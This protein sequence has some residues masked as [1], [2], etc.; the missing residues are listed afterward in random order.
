MD[1]SGR[2][3]VTPPPWWEQTGP[4][5]VSALLAAARSGDEAA[6]ADLV[7]R[8]EPFLSALIAGAGIDRAAGESI[9]EG[10][11]TRLSQELD[12]IDDEN[13]LITWVVRAVPRYTAGRYAEVDGTLNG[14]S[15]TERRL[16]RFIFRGESSYADI[17]SSLDM[18][19]GSVGPARQRLFRRLWRLSRSGL[20][21][22]E[23]DP[24]PDR[25]TT[26]D[27]LEAALRIHGVSH[28]TAS[29]EH[30]DGWI[31][32]LA[33]AFGLVPPPWPSPPPGDDLVVA[34]SRDVTDAA[35]E[36]FRD[37]TRVLSEH[38]VLKPEAGD[39][40]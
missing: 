5:R 28:R 13:S 4:A 3:S 21:L 12:G 29:P 18:P 23:F 40:R 34:A 14:L 8:I 16:L 37:F 15:G 7:G 36:T 10:V 20:P 30:K 35:R 25:A 26:R 39:R 38:A 9:T 1:E 22:E 31:H 19:V 32:T 2:T 27:D 33:R 6:W 17:A 11:Y 24:R